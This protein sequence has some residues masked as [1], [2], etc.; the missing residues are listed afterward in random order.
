M[1]LLEPFDGSRTASAHASRPLSSVGSWGQNAA[2]RLSLPVQSATLY[3]L[4]ADA[5]SLDMPK[6]NRLI[7]SHKTELLFCISEQL[8]IVQ[9]FR[10]RV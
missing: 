9:P 1:N 6:I 3:W 5:I 10:I 4:W 7:M 8:I 2:L